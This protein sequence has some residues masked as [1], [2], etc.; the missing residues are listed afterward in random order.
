[1]SGSTE[2]TSHIA[3]GDVEGTD[4][5]DCEGESVV[6]LGPIEGEGDGS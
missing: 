1:M 3:D 2:L 5:G 4:D 6:E